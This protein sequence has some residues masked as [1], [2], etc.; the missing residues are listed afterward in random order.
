MTYRIAVDTGGTFNDFVVQNAETGEITVLKVSSTPAD[1]SVAVM[2]GLQ[3]LSDLG[4]SSSDVQS[5]FHGTTVGT[6]AL[7]EK[8][9]ARVGLLITKGFRAIYEVREQTR[10]FGKVIYDL[11][12]EKPIPLVWP[13]LTEEVSER[14]VADGSVLTELDVEAAR[15]A[16]ARLKTH[17][18]QSVAVALLF[19]FLNTRHE[20]MVGRLATDV[21]PGVPVSLSSE[22]LPQIREY[23]RMSTTVVNAYLVPVLSRYLD[24]LMTRLSE[25]GLDV[26]GLFVMQSNGGVASFSEAGSR[27]VNTALSGPAGG[28]IAA[29]ELGQAIGQENLITFDIGGTSCDVSLVHRGVPSI[30][31]LAKIGGYDVATPQI[32]IHT[33]SAGGGTIA[34]VDSVGVLKVGP[35]SAGADPGPVAYGRG[36]QNVTVTDC[37]LALGRL[38]TNLLGGALVLDREAA[39]EAVASQIADPLGMSV[40]DA[41]NAVIRLLNV[42]M[43]EAIKAIS[44]QRGYDLREFYLVAFGGGGPVHACRIVQDLGMRGVV[45]PLFP[46]VMSALGLLLADVRHDFVRSRLKPW[47]EVAPQE[48]C[49]MVNE[50]AKEGQDFLAREGFSANRIRFEYGVDLRYRGQGYELT[51]PIQSLPNSVEDRTRLRE[52]F[53]A[54]HEERFGHRASDADVELVAMRVAAIGVVQRPI[55]RGVAPRA[56]LGPGSRRL[57]VFSDTGMIET[58]I[59]SRHRLGPNV[60]IAGPAIIAQYDTTIVVEPGFTARVDSTMNVILEPVRSEGRIMGS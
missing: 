36:G 1:P 46:G 38:G 51:V 49:E 19:S 16:L 37:N 10:G 8:T 47:S 43:E 17:D 18:V 40:M 22:I 6:N 41:A 23:Y 57:V 26:E 21:L 45:V 35:R 53:D 25:G 60:E 20:K 24:R 42:S 59:Y 54:L 44:S 3:H 27:A 50:M 58:P 39:Q 34:W 48:I 28:V 5:F 56:N 33:I 55:I 31:T 52:A 2:A 7:L 15:D 29:V 9:G 13:D 14:I 12:Y 32:D 11:S 30:T 4:I